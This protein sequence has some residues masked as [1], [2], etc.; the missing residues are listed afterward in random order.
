MVGRGQ[1]EGEGSSCYHVMPWALEDE[2]AEV[3]GEWGCWGTSAPL[4]QAAYEGW[5]PQS[6]WK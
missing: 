1:L 3:Q 2:I 5:V 6:L 4:L